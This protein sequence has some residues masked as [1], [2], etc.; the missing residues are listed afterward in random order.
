ME[1][2]RGGGPG[3]FPS[4]WAFLLLLL[5]HTDSPTINTQKCS[6]ICSGV[7]AYGVFDFVCV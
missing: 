2:G 5:D 3:D 7:R 4:R 1:E 6:S